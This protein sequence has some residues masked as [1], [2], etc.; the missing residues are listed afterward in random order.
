M[1]YCLRCGLEFPRKCN[2]NKHLSRKKECPTSYLDLPPEMVRDEY[3]HYY[4]E[5]VKVRN[6]HLPSESIPDGIQKVSKT[7]LNGIQK[8]SGMDCEHCGK[9]FSHRN[10]CYRH[11]RSRCKVVKLE[12]EKM[13]L[14][15][16]FL[17]AKYNQLKLEYEAKMDEQKEDFEEQKE[18]FMNRVE[19]LDQK[20][21]DLAER[22]LVVSNGTD[23]DGSGGGDVS[24]GGD[25]ARSVRP[26]VAQFGRDRAGSV[27]A[28]GAI[29]L[30]DA[31]AVVGEGPPHGRAGIVDGIGIG[32]GLARAVVAEG[33]QHARGRGTPADGAIALADAGAVVGEGAPDGRAGGVDTV[34]VPPV[35][36]DV[37]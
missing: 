20:L 22:S 3:D 1:K 9:H 7:I 10:N 27:P 2:L 4:N 14:T 29:A 28:D 16:Q 25:G 31:G 23:A 32:V 30:A 26:E 15:K 21:K 36:A 8:Q 37:G 24:A 12:Q 19:E 17:D 11:K 34:A 6:I 35:V 33:A 18:E 13:D 5:F